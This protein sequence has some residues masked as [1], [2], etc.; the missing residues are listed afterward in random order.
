MEARRV[1]GR[2][3]S[4]LT[5]ERVADLERLHSKA[6]GRDQCPPRADSIHTASRAT[7]GVNIFTTA[8][9]KRVV[10]VDRIHEPQSK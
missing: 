2:R 8:R 10:P 5:G 7:K 6:R 4:G 3:A 1:Q 9:N